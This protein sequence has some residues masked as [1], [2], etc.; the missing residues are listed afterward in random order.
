MVL[1][2]YCTLQA[3]CSR[4]ATPFLHDSAAPQYDS[5]DHRSQ[6]RGAGGK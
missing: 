5:P 1:P 6:A 3:F 4:L 2:V